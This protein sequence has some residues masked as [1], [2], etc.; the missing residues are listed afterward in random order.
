MNFSREEFICDESRSGKLTQQQVN[1][2]WLSLPTTG[3]MWID[4][5]RAFVQANDAAK[6]FDL[7]PVESGVNMK[8]VRVA[9]KH[10]KPLRRR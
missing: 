9:E 10:A 2:V 1:S 5:G 8:A 6:A 3:S 7:G 4:R